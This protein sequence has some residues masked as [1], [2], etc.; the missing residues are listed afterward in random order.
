MPLKSAPAHSVCVSV[1]VLCASVCMCVRLCQDLDRAHQYH[2][3]QLEIGQELQ[4]RAAQGRAS[5]NLGTLVLPK[6]PFFNYHH[7]LLYDGIISSF[8]TH[9]LR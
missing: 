2:Q 5:S 7:Q 6:L 9:L 4:D 8:K 1:R 3:H